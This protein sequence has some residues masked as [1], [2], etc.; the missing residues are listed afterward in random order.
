MKHSRLLAIAILLFSIDAS[1]EQWQILGTQ[2]LGMGGAF[3]AIAQGPNGQYWNPAGLGQEKNIS[4]LS[5]PVAVRAEFT[6]GLLKDAYK[7]S[8][9]ASDYS[10]LKTSQ[11]NG[12]SID[13]AQM[14][15]LT[16]GVAALGGLNSPGKGVL[17]DVNGGAAIK[18]SK[19]AFSVNNFTSVGATPVIDTV[20]IGLGAATGIAGANM[21]QGVL[22]AGTVDTTITAANQAASDQIETALTT[23]GYANLES[24]ICGAA[25]CLATQN[26]AI[27]NASTLADALVDQAED[28]GL[29]A[30]QITQ[31]AQKIAD[32]AGAAAPI[33]IAAASGNPYTNNTSN[34]T[35]RGG[36]FTE[37]ALGYGRG[38]LLPGLYLGANLKMI[39]GTVG[40]DRY[41]IM[42]E[43]A[44]GD[45][46]FKNFDKYSKT[47]SQLGIDV[48]ALCELNKIVPILPFKPRA[49][50]MIRNINRPKFDMPDTA[51][52]NGEKSDYALDAQARLGTAIKPFGFWTVSMDMDLTENSTP[53]PG[54][55]SRMFGLGTEI[56]V[57]NRRWLNIPLRAGLMKNMAEAS[58]KYTYTAGAGFNIIHF[59]LDLGVAVS[60]DT[61][62]YTDDKGK[63]VTVPANAAGSLR[64]GFLF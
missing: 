44:S 26:G 5:I 59:V 54:F 27:T 49:G 13:T 32:N 58:S 19:F 39:R 3:V 56:N 11:T 48:G 31:A 64:L 20:N 24:L 42:T 10:K 15:A 53:V 38:F 52:T 29:T 25:G 23:I 36:S 4:G 33:I 21:N 63:E 61:T 37:A 45:N 34:L 6:G 57:F 2:A 62:K 40:Y 22:G 30:D 8:N 47:T 43:K 18:V 35:L 7:L 9:V 55:K 14:A 50:L 17:I 28:S 16:Q 1:A 46:I 51:I 41:G 12:T 60:A